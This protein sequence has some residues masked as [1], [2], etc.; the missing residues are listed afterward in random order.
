[1]EARDRVS[2]GWNYA[3]SILPATA[4]MLFN[5]KIALGAGELEASVKTVKK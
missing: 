2:G 4:S 5:P 1:M 3:R